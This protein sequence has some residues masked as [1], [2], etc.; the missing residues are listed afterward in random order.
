MSDPTKDLTSIGTLAA[1]ARR[2]V[3]SIRDF[4]EREGI[5]PSMQLNGVP[6]FDRGAVDQIIRDSQPAMPPPRGKAGAL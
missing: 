2:G 3:Q 4:C 1:Q 5:R 6:Y